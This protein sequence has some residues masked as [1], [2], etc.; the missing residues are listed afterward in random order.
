MKYTV[1]INSIVSVNEIPNTWTI[2]DKKALLKAFGLDEEIAPNEIDEMIQ[3]AVSDFEPNEAAE[4]VLS[5]RLSD[6]LNEGQIGQIAND[7][8]IDKVCEEYPEIGLH[9]ELFNVNQFLYKAY[10]GKFPNAKA[11]II[12]FEIT[13][14][15]PGQTELTKEQ[16]LKAF[17]SGL[18]DNS[19]LKRLFSDHMEGH[20]SFHDAEDIVWILTKKGDNTYQ[21]ITSDYWLS[22]EDFGTLEFES[23]YKEFVEEE[24][25]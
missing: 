2:D 25:H 7:M 17:S 16:S 22:N 20:Q 19:L 24:E 14:S 4:I 10:N 6:Q 11:N 12:D 15:D 1:K 9:H 18:R 3:L 8:L 5:Y 13:C 21:L 23:E